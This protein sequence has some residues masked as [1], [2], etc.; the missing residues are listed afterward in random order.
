MFAKD[1]EI[2]ITIIASTA[3]MVFLVAVI[4]FAVIRYQNKLKRHLQEISDLK[5][6]FHKE[7]LNAQFE[8]EEQTLHRVSQEIH[9]NIGQILSLV[10][11]NLNTMDV[12]TCTTVLQ[13]KVVFTKDM[14][15]KAIND[16]RQL[17]KSL[18]N[19]Y[20]KQQYLSESIK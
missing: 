7:V 4:V 3:L 2:F 9:D 15:G 10:K 19:T 14:V 11:L 1:E 6:A 20:L 18:N 8:K 16:L 5:I 13:D 17:S 12:S